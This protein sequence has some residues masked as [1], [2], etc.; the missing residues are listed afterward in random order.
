MPINGNV[1]ILTNPLPSLTLSG[2]GAIGEEL[3]FK[4]YGRPRHRLLLILSDRAGFEEVSGISGF[5][6][7]ASP[8][9]SL[10]KVVGAGTF[11][12]DEPLEGGSFVPD[13]KSLIGKPLLVQALLLPMDPG[14]TPVLSN[15]V[16]GVFRDR[17]R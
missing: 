17:P 12:G 13:E 8:G 1:E 15:V 5:P 4:V 7:F 9:G 10:F 3:R 16:G 6:L 14:G 11:T 2:S